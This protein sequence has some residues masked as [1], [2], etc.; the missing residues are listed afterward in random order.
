MEWGNNARSYDPNGFREEYI[1][2]IDKVWSKESR[3]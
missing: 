3:Y 1:E 2:L